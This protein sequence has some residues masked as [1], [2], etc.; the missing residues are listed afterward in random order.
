M[1]KVST[2]KADYYSLISKRL[3]QA[4]E[5]SGLKQSTI[6]AIAKKRNYSLRQS[7]LSKML[8]KEAQSISLKN[9]VEL[10]NI[11]ELDL[12]NLLSTDPHAVFNPPQKA[13]SHSPSLIYRAD[14]PEMRAYLNN[15]YTYF[16]P[17]KSSDE[18]I[19]KGEL[20]FEASPDYSKCNAYFK[21]DTGQIYRNKERYGEKII[22]EYVGEL[23][24]SPSLGVSYCI[25]K[26][27]EIGEISFIMFRYIRKLNE[28]LESRNALVITPCAGDHRMP[29]AHRMI[30]TQTALDDDDLS[31]LQGQ[32][33]LNE[34][35]I[36]I[37]KKGL[38]T[39]FKSRKKDL[40]KLKN[41]SNY[42]LSSD[43]NNLS[44][45]A[46]QITPHNTSDNSSN[47]QDFLGIRPSLYYKFD[48]SVIRSAF[49]D[50]NTKIKAINL[51]REYSESPKYNKI[52]D[53]CDEII[54][55]Y[56]MQKSR[57]K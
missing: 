17:T 52:G 11:L 49:L 33:Y 48:E 7:T 5:S 43:K 28:N 30:I 27:E 19:L 10:S 8:S 56:I 14:H 6:I 15:Y 47:A 2:A 34:S 1:P 46:K 22:K 4:V 44:A 37:S 40:S 54:Y 39:L 38:D 16:F 35:D 23:I 57:N 36:L 32:L 55:E 45:K 29:T 9:V 21:L 41:Y 12:N 18:N 13:E 20:S 31:Y 42:S 24:L 50:K 53:K 51:L 3:R 26:N 25:L